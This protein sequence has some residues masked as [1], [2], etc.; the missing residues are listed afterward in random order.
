MRSSSP[1]EQS[2]TAHFLGPHL[3][4]LRASPATPAPR[5][6][7]DPVDRAT[8]RHS[9]QWHARREAEMSAICMELAAVRFARG[10]AQSAAVWPC[11]AELMSDNS[12]A[13]RACYDMVL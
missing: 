3:L 10:S 9:Q 6:R 8:E 12:L 13:H 5:C 4:K 7:P 2:S 1:M 11:L